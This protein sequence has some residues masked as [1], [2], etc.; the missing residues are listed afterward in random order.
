MTVTHAD[1]VNEP[2]LCHTCTGTSLPT[3]GDNALYYHRN[4]Q[5]SIIGLTNAA[6][7]LVERY[8]YTAYGT[9]GIYDPRGTVRSTSIYANRY[10]YTGREYDA[11]LALYHFRARWYDPSAGGFISRDPLGYVDG[12]SLYRGYFGVDGIDPSGKKWGS[13]II[14]LAC[15]GMPYAMCRCLCANGEHWDVVGEP[16]EDCVWKCL[17]ADIAKNGG[18][19]GQAYSATCLASL[20][21]CLGRSVRELQKFVGPPS[22]IPKGL[23]PGNMGTATSGGW[24][25]PTR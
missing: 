18:W 20:A 24:R 16:W 10:T 4:Q 17:D 8:S 15:G 22:G 9:L 6:G 14:A 23:P 2:I 19:A 7:T 12:M 3:T 25:P 21:A 1:A 11:D 13:C 5:Y